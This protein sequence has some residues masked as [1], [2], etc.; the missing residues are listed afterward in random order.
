MASNAH[1]PPA[2]KRPPPFF[3]HVM[4]QVAKEIHELGPHIHPPVPNPAPLGLFAFGLTTALLQVKHT[5][6]AGE[7]VEDAK[8]TENLTWGFALFYG[9]LLQVVAGIAEIKRNN[10]F[11]FTAF[12][13][14]GGF[15]LSLG[16]AHIVALL[17]DEGTVIFS[18]KAVQAM[19]VLMGIFTFLLWICTLKMNATISLLFFLLATTFFT[20][21]GGVENDTLDEAA[22]WIGMATAATAYWLGAAELVNDIWGEGRE[23]IPLGSFSRNKFKSTGGAH[24]PGRIHGVAHRQ[25]LKGT[26]ME[27]LRRSSVA[28]PP[29][30]HVGLPPRHV[31]V[32]HHPPIVPTEENSHTDD[33]VDL[34]AGESH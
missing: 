18:A 6:L 30:V 20:L 11:G 19:L 23:V 33:G 2:V 7:D 14:Y 5:H 15:W 25:V 32:D 9:G 26:Q 22:G 29:G 10:V 1:P 21:A 16:T 3:P 12:T 17:A 13:S 31:A 4:D 24:V 28:C 8:G 34:E 27:N